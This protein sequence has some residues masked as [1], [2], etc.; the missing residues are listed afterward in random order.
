[1]SELRWNPVLEEWVVTATQRQDRT[2]FPPP[3]YDP[4][5]PTHPGGFPTEIPA[6]TYEIVVFE[7]KFPSFRR[8]APFPNVKGTP[9]TP[10]LPAQG[11]CEVVCYTPEYNAELATLPV[12][13]VEELVL[14]WADRFEELGA[15]DYVRY[16]YIFENKGKEI[17]VT[18]AHPHGQ[19]YAYPFIPPIPAREL[20]AARRHFQ[21]TGRDLLG[22]VLAQEMEDGRRIVALN[23]DFV[24]FVPFFARY[25]YE[26]HIL[27]RALRPAITD[28]NDTEQRNLAL[29]LNV[30][31]LK[32]NNLWNR[33]M[34]YIM[35][36]HQRP[37][38]GTSAEYDYYRF[39]IEFYPPYRTPDK[40]KYLAGSE[41]GAGVFIN[42]THAETT[43][44]ALREAA[45]HSGI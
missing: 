7:N 44:Q 5:A 13:K 17:G 22:D 38:D 28:F 26:V 11:I 42:D 33:S 35:L 19:I 9:L 18:L 10:V 6:P 2:F 23:D 1:M 43:A 37:S 32:Y 27:P 39:H 31:M 16:V 4:L 20:N 12:E 45:P 24:A 29:I 15:H 25:P 3:D 34:P 41:A 36:M 14:V 8:E 40:L 30:V 21:T